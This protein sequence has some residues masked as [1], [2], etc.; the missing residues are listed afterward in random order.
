MASAI[1][2]PSSSVNWSGGKESSCTTVTVHAEEQSMTVGSAIQGLD[3]ADDS[4]GS[5]GAELPDEATTEGADEPE[6]HLRSSARA[7]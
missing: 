6:D 5:E 2:A 3:Q 4:N 1:C 7:A